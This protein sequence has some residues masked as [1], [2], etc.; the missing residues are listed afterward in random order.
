MRKRTAEDF[1]FPINRCLKSG[2]GPEQGRFSDAV[3]AQKT[4]QFATV[5][6]GLNMGGHEFRAVFI[7]VSD[8]QIP[9]VDGRLFHSLI[10]F[11]RLLKRTYTTIGAPISAVMELTGNAPSK[12][13]MRAIRLHSR[14]SDEPVSMAAGINTR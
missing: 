13:G 6:L 8:T 14:A 2:E 9:N 11:L 1:N 5:D 10:S 4:G 12:P 3:R 7:G